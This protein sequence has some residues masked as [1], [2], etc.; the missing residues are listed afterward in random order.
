M[1]KRRVGRLAV[2]W[3]WGQGLGIVTQSSLLR[4]FDPIEMYGVIESL[5][6]TI[7][8]LKLERGNHSVGVDPPRTY[9]STN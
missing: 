4:V 5:Q 2:S 6:Q 7:Q 9:P 8:Q 3:N 1:Q